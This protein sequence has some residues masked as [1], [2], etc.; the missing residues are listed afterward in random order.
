VPITALDVLLGVLLPAVAAALALLAMR[1]AAWAPG[2][3]AALVLGLGYAAAHLAQ[4]GWRGFPPAESSDWPWVAALGGAL[5][6]ASGLTRAGPAPLRLALRLLASGAL[7][8][9]VLG[10]WRRGV[11][12]GSARSAVALM[13]AGAALV[14]SVLELRQPGPGWFTAALLALVAGGAA[15]AIGLS[16]SAKLALLA[17]AA[18]ALLSA[19]ALA[20]ALRLGPALLPGAAAPVTLVLAALLLAAAH[21]SD[22]PPRALSLLAAAPVLGLLPRAALGEA[23]CRRGHDVVSLLLVAGAVALAVQAAV[24][25]SPEWDAGSY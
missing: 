3:G 1:R 21:Y 17:G 5:L 9:L 11:D 25:A 15:A 13:G 16:G 6:G 8:W 22:L 12:P 14:W 23:R 19:A 10:A 20:A 18:C 2:A 7:A 4:R 24:D